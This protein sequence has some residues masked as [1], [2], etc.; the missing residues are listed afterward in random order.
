MKRLMLGLVFILAIGLA[1]SSC[2]S[3]RYKGCPSTNKRY[4]TG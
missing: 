4:F 3:Q 2:A 1:I